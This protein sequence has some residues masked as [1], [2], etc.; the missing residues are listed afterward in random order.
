MNHL[1]L[2]WIM[3]CLSLIVFTVSPPVAKGP[4]R[5]KKTRVFKKASTG[6]VSLMHG[7]VIKVDFIMLD[8]QVTFHWFKTD[9][10]LSRGFSSARMID[11]FKYSNQIGNMESDVG[12]L[13][14]WFYRLET[15]ES[16]TT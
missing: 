2:E 5:E 9:N 7:K 6:R 10:D 8:I 16:R 12:T 4:I 3:T 11:V 14:N 15:T 13:T 1:H